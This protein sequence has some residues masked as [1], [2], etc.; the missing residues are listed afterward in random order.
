[1]GETQGNSTEED[2]QTSS[3][4]I[5]MLYQTYMETVPTIDVG[6]LRGKFNFTDDVNLVNP[7]M[8]YQS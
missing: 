6:Y 7:S 8:R 1:M 5:V 4:E 2:I 3:R